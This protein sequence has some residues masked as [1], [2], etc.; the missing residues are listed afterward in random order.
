MSLTI[1]SALANNL[2]EKL[3]QF[4]SKYNCL[5]DISIFIQL[6]II[7]FQGTYYLLGSILANEV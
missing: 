4:F 7:F 6:Q 3:I 2:S 5:K 1:K